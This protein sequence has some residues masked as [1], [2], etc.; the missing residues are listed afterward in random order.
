MSITHEIWLRCKTDY[1]TGKGSLRDVAG[2]HGVAK[3]SVE[4]KARNEGWT[5]LR[6]EFEAAQLAKLIPSAPPT[7]PPV[8]VAPGGVVSD[9]W[10][11]QRVDIYYQRNAELLD[12]ARGLLAKK[13]ADEK[14]DLGTDGLAKLT[15][16][17]GGIV[18]A[19]NKLLGLN[20]RQKGRP[21]RP[22]PPTASFVEDYKDEK[23]AVGS[24]QNSPP[25]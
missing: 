24:P 8:P 12:K 19:E 17:L 5:R 2:R 1:L 13:L 16:A 20:H 18:D 15:S 10:L 25:Q 14:G 9:S 22:L 7:L 23:P 6:H 4:K 3:S 21:R 11:A